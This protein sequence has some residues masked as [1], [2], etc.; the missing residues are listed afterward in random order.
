MGRPRALVSVVLG[1]LLLA[2]CGSG[3]SQ[4]RAAILIGDHEI[5]VD[6]VQQVIDRAVTQEPAAQ[7][8]AQQHKLD[9]LGRAIVGQ[10]VVHEMITRAAQREGLR[11][12]PALV[13]QAVNA[14]SQPSPT[15]GIDPAVLAGDIALRARDHTEA[16]TDYVLERAL[17]EKYFDKLSVDFDYTTVSTDDNGPRREQAEAKA[18]QFAA[19]PNAATTLVRADAGA[20]MDAELGTTLPALQS[21]MFAGSVLFGVPAGTVVS[22]EA[23]PSQSVW[24]VA[25]IRKRDLNASPAVDQAQQ[26]TAGQLASVGIRLLQ[27]DVERSGVKINPRYGVWDPVAMDVAPS[28][29]EVSG[30]VLPV[31]G[32]VQP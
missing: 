16:A 27:Q 18:K 12:D 7:Q 21:P 17:G 2:G 32:Y 28:A 3:P 15:S 25:V 9:L 11:A 26:A 30:F 6:Q 14:L 13:A 20:G 22:F 19:S 1:C 23:D 29:A 10:L 5:T 24:L 31:E 8:L 4:T